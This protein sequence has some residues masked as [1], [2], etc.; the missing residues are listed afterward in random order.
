MGKEVVKRGGAGR[1]QGRKPVKQGEETVTLS[2]RVTV[3]Q[4]EKL[5]RLGGAEWVR[6]KIDR[7]KEPNVAGNR[8]AG[9]TSG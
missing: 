2:L 3:A 4:R 1:G 6:G 9:G 7:A 8:R 5:A